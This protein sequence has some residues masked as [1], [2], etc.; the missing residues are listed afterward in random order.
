[1]I[2][3]SIVVNKGRSLQAEAW[4]KLRTKSAHKWSGQAP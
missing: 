3:P 2:E 1:M 4:H